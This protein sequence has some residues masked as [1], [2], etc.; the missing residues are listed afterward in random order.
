M[1]ETQNKTVLITGALGR[2]GRLLCR[3]FKKAGYSVIAT[4][5]DSG[6][7]DCEFFVRVDTCHMLLEEPPRLFRNFVTNAL[8][9]RKLDLLIHNAT[10][11]RELELN[12]VSAA[13]FNDVLRCNVVAPLLLTKALVKDLLTP[14]GTVIFTTSAYR[15]AHLSRRTEYLAS[16]AALVGLIAAL[17]EELQ[18]EIDIFGVGSATT[19]IIDKTDD[20]DRYAAS[21]ADACLR[22]VRD[23]NFAPSGSVLY[24]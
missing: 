7:C 15:H 5:R 14:H 24:L 3:E 20:A 21:I 8:R 19:S 17:A 1:S 13:S 22:V 18:D 10:I 4:D 11:D 6:V 23:R 2:T 16:K 9:G 12:E